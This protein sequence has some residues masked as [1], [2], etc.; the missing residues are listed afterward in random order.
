MV[1]TSA[2]V[3]K[4]LPKIQYID[5]LIRPLVTCNSA[6]TYRVAKILD[7]IFGTTKISLTTVGLQIAKS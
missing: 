6:L 1:K 7:K 3:L 4:G 5:V 2:P